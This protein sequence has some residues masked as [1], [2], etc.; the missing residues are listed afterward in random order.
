MHCAAAC[1]HISIVEYLVSTKGVSS[2]N[3]HVD[4]F[5][6]ICKAV[7]GNGF[8]FNNLRLCASKYDH[9]TV[10]VFLMHNGW[11]LSENLFSEVLKLFLSA[12]NV[13]DLDYLMV[14]GHE[15]MAQLRDRFLSDVELI[16]Y[17]RDLK[18]A[19]YLLT[20]GGLFLSAELIANFAA[21]QFHRPVV[22]DEL[23]IFATS[24]SRK[25]CDSEVLRYFVQCCPHGVFSVFLKVTS[26][27]HPDIRRLKLTLLDYACQR[28]IPVLM[29]GIA[30]R[31]IN[32][33][34]IKGRTPLHVACEHDRPELVSFLIERGCDQSALNSDGQLPL[35][36]AAAH[37]SFEIVKLVSC[38]DVNRQDNAGNTPFHLACKRVVSAESVKTLKYLAF[39]KRCKRGV[40]NSEQE[41]PLHIL[42]GSLDKNSSQL[43][44]VIMKVIDSCPDKGVVSIEDGEGNTLLHIA[45][46][47]GSVNLI[48]FLVWEKMSD[49]SKLNR[50][51]NLPLHIIL[52]RSYES[53]D[54]SVIQTLSHGMSM[55]SL[56]Q[57]N[58]EGKTVL[59]LACSNARHCGLDSIRYLVFDKDCKPINT[60]GLFSDL[61]IEFACSDESNFDL[62]S[63][64][65]TEENV[66]GI[67]SSG[68]PLLTACTRHNVKAVRHFIQVLRCKCDI[69]RSSHVPL[70]HYACRESAEMVDLIAGHVDVNAYSSDLTP[71]HVACQHNMIDVVELLVNKYKCDQFKASNDYFRKEFPLHLACAKSLALVKLLSVTSELLQTVTASGYT[72]LH[73]AF[74]HCKPDIVHYFLEDLKYSLP[75]LLSNSSRCYASLLE[76]ACEAGSVEL[77]KCLVQNGVN[78]F[79]KSVSGNTPLHIACSSGSVEVVQYLIDNGHDT[80]CFNL[81]RELPVHIA[82]AKSLD[83]VKITSIN[84]TA[85][86]LEDGRVTALCIAASCGLLDIVRYLVEVKHCSVFSRGDY[87]CNVL[88]YA[89]GYKGVFPAVARYLVQQGCN[90]VDSFR[91]HFSRTSSIENSVSLKNFE[92]LKALTDDELNINCQDEDGNSPLMLVC[93]C[94]SHKSHSFSLQ[95]VKY[96]LERKCHQ[97]ILNKNNEIALHMVCTHAHKFEI[98]QQLDC[99][100][101][102]IHGTTCS[103]TAVKNINGNTPLHIACQNKFLK[104]L[105]HLVTFCSD[106]DCNIQNDKGQSLLHIAVINNDQK[107]LDYLLHKVKGIISTLKDSEG[108]APV[109]YARSKRMLISLIKHDKAN[110]DLR[111]AGG[112]T[113]LH[114][115]CKTRPCD[116]ASVSYLLCRAPVRSENNDGDTPLHL[117]CQ[118]FPRE[119]VQSHGRKKEGKCDKHGDVMKCLLCHCAPVN[120]QNK[121]G[122]TP[123]HIA[124]LRKEFT[125][126][127]ILCDRNHNIATQN[128]LGDTPL[129]IACAAG[130]FSIVDCILTT[131]SSSISALSI[132]N[133]LGDL[134]FH[135]VLAKIQPGKKFKRSQTAF[136]YFANNCSDVNVQNNAGETFLHLACNGNNPFSVQ[137]VEFFVQ[138]NADIT[139][140]DC[141]MQLPLHIAASKSLALVKLC[142]TPDIVNRQD[143]DG[144]TPLHI[145]CLHGARKII[146]FLLAEMECIPNARNNNGQ[147]PLH[148]LSL[149]A[150]YS[151]LLVHHTLKRE[152]NLCLQDNNGDTPLHTCSLGLMPVILFVHCR[153]IIWAIFHNKTMQEKLHSSQPVKQLILT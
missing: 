25:V 44:N 144:N 88:A 120:V 134:P 131:Q 101:L 107:T 147:T 114:I 99:S 130:S 33:R 5:H 110:I 150:T 65:S 36:V 21:I 87:E 47:A 83:M 51:S 70:L 81:K 152:E 123:L 138:L 68:G 59:H 86:E 28:S 17:I 100:S 143:K 66:N 94:A 132:A 93:K 77:V 64:L 74:K 112:N 102:A 31:T 115:Y 58:N 117:A 8:Y 92:L 38:C 54:V 53:V 124:C 97:H 146:Q 113:P 57:K 24:F 52:A 118:D 63:M 108:A 10:I 27:M 79:E 85:A 69:L 76:L 90:P 109:H 73:I 119:Q 32:M 106:E 139:I 30:E 128:K 18:M 16:S 2:V 126:V 39:D 22:I 34:D 45:C 49:V 60:P 37:S 6:T 46:S 121:D 125:D 11:K 72:P 122:N 15:S 61:D 98:L 71:L 89:S 42:I 127:R 75:S 7:K 9:V 4:I 151:A 43:D 91:I 82:C 84:C 67:N 78:S 104:A 153:N 14:Q 23:K 41:L 50:D 135:A 12:G 62:L 26:D 3:S 145:A 142:C 103:Y 40:R 13:S 95:S 111:D 29:K 129:H 80:K 96:L 133:N 137:L 55:T 116:L 105:K 48:R 149:R 35:H 56:L 148:C 140:I 19:K 136:E 1:G 20:C 141:H